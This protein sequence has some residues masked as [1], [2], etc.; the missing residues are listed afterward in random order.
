MRQQ[1]GRRRRT[2]MSARLPRA[3]TFDGDGG[4]GAALVAGNL[5]AVIAD[6]IAA[7]EAVVAAA[8]AFRVSLSL[9][10]VPQADRPLP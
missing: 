10:D 7:T 1:S 4:A 9:D 8:V 3:H 6:C 2:S 5:D